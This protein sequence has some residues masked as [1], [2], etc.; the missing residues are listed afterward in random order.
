ML[1][2]FKDEDFDNKIK[3]EEYDNAAITMCENICIGNKKLISFYINCYLPQ[4]MY[5]CL[6]KYLPPLYLTT[7]TVRLNSVE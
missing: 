2:D 4:K 7:T 5:Y 1:I 3:N 6:Q